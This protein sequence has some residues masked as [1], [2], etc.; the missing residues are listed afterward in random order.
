MSRPGCSCSRRP[1]VERRPRQR[2][3]G[4]RSAST[5]AVLGDDCVVLAARGAVT[6]ETML[7]LHA[8]FAHVARNERTLAID[9]CEVDVP[10]A[11]AV[12]LLTS[13][14]RRLRSPR[15]RLVVAC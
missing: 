4:E 7:R 11:A 1:P 15:G 9:L 13:A 5:R 12:T 6:V 8:A 14:V 2:T 10:T 3:E